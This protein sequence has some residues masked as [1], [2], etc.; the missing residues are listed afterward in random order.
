MATMRV[1]QGRRTLVTGAGSD[2]GSAVCGALTE[3]GATVVATDLPGPR[4]DAVARMP[5]VSEI[6]P[7]DVCDLPAT[8]M[9]GADPFDVLVCVAGLVDVSRFVDSDPSRWDALWR[10]N[11]RAPIALSHVL[12]GSMCERR[13][14]RIVFISSESARAGAGGEAVYAATKAGL[15]GFGKSLAREVAAAGVT[16]NVVSPG[17]IDTER[18]RA[19][20]DA[21]G[22]MR[23]ALLRAIPAR[24]FGE[25]ADIAAAVAYLCVPAA[26]YVTGQ[27]LSVN[28]GITMV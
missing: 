4:L 23:D 15:L 13:W 20:L 7:A 22:G 11:L 8:S 25:P 16:V 21:H 28:G 12:V 2:I 26:R 1:L 27:T 18:S 17:V 5:G 19:I 24:T 14:G 3:L 10:V 6:W 9:L